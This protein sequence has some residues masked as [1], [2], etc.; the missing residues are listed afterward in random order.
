M[1]RLV[2][3]GVVK[4]R[5]VWSLSCF[6]SQEVETL[7]TAFGLVLRVIRD[8][9]RIITVVLLRE[10]EGLLRNWDMAT[11]GGDDLS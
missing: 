8:R 7:Y 5:E 6:T 1:R 9:E 10:C 4:L 11:V 3:S 2:E